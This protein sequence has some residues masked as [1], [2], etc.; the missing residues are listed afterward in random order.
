MEQTTSVLFTILEQYLSSKPSSWQCSSLLRG[1]WNFHLSQLRDIVLDVL[2]MF[3][4]L[5]VVYICKANNVTPF[6]SEDAK[7]LRAKDICLKLES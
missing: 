6:C 3:A 1:S 7:D 4:N 2:P 5:L